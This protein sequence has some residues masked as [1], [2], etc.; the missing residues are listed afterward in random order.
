MSQPKVQNSAKKD[1]NTQVQPESPPSRAKSFVGAQSM[2]F[3]SWLL[4]VRSD[5]LQLSKSLGSVVSGDRGE[6]AVDFTAGSIAT[7]VCSLVLEVVVVRKNGCVTERTE[8][9]EKIRIYKD[10]R[11]EQ[12]RGGSSE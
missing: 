1:P 12:S 3:V 10:S 5:S 9:E 2:T 11:G 4:E 6:F 8:T 7:L